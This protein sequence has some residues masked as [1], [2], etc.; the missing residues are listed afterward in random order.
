M[1]SVIVNRMLVN[2]L[3]EFLLAGSRDTAL[4]S[5]MIED[6]R[7]YILDNLDKNLSLESLSKRANLSP[8]HFARTFKRHVGVSPH[9]FLIDAR[10]NLAAF[11]LKSTDDPIK[12]IAYACGFSSE[13]TFCTT[14]KNRL[15]ITPSRYRMDRKAP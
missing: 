11:Y 5:T 3:T 1:D 8:Y 9:D 4:G 15:G 14:F 13:S 7:S 2:I 12:N 6:I 10:V